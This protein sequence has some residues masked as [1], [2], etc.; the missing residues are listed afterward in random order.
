MKLSALLGAA[1]P[2]AGAAQE[3]AIPPEMAEARLTLGDTE[4][5]IARNQDP[6][7]RIADDFAKTSRA[8]PPFCIHPMSA[9][10]GVETVGE[11]D[12][13]TLIASP[14]TR[15]LGDETEARLEAALAGAPEGGAAQLYTV[16]P[17]DSLARIALAHYGDSSRYTA[18]WEANRDTIKRPNLIR[19]GQEIR[20]PPLEG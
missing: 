20:I 12:T 3:V 17:G 14:V 5:V 6:E 15:S 1:G 13:E 11:I 10:E 8:C 7:A 19:V 18:I 4:I 16:R 9:T 2:I